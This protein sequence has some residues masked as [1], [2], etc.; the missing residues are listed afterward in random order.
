MKRSSLSDTSAEQ[1]A[2]P[3]RA[4]SGQLD[5][6]SKSKATLTS[7]YNSHSRELTGY[8][9]KAFGDGPPD[10]E[11]VAQA[12]FQKLAEM[13]LSGIRNLKAFLWRTAR[14]LTLTEKRNRNIR[15]RF[16]FEIEHLYFA[17]PGPDSGPQRVLEVEQQLE[18]IDKALDRMPEKRKRAFLLHRVDGLNLTAV[19]KQMGLSPR[20]I[21]KHISRAVSDIEDALAGSESQDE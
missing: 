1:G 9:R 3:E 18:I 6:Q 15:S 5:L 2:L 17:A 14:N 21:V 20:A 19:G 16:D 10:P 8:L 4:K 11:D 7:I 12:A 13:D